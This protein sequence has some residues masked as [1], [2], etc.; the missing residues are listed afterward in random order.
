MMSM[1]YSSIG[2]SILKILASIKIIVFTISLNKNIA[3]AIS[4]NQYNGDKKCVKKD[5]EHI[6]CMACIE[7]SVI[8]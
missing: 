2:K 5:I 1:H 4:Y 6:E 3:Y 8:A 7:C